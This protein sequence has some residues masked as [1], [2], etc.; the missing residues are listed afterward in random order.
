VTIKDH[1][2]IAF[3]RRAKRKCD[4]F[5]SGYREGIEGPALDYVMKVYSSHRRIPKG[6]ESLY[7]DR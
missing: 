5:M 3:M 1:L 7:E 4:R 2:P 6:V